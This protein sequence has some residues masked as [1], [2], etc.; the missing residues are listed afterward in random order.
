LRLNDDTPDA[1]AL[2]AAATEPEPIAA[3]DKDLGS[4]TAI[5][6]VTL[7]GIGAF[8]N[9]YATQPILPLLAKLFH[10]SKSAV[11]MTVS[12]STLG[13]AIAA[14]IAGALAEHL[15]RRRV[16]ITSIFLLALP[17]MLAATSATLPALVWWRFLQGV[18]MPG[19]F[20]VTIAYITEE[21]S[22]TAVAT[23]MSVYV[24]G[25]VLGGFLGRVF[26]GFAATHTVLPHVRPSWHVGFIAIGVCDLIF[27]LLIWRW[28]PLDRPA[29]TVTRRFNPLHHFRNRQ[30]LATYAVGFSVLFSLV[31][32][33]TYITFHLAAPP[34]E[35]TP[36]QLSWLFV[37]YL[38]GLFVTPVAGV[39][40]GRVGS[41]VSLIAA[42][43]AAM[44]GVSLTLVHSLP[45]ILL[46]LVLC[47]SGVFVC[48]SASTSYIQRAA[49]SGG[50]SSAAGQYVSFYYIGGS[51]AGVLPAYV[52]NHGEWTACVVLV[53]IV[54]A[55]TIAIAAT[56]WES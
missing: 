56:V 35:L 29:H 28:L 30:L 19:I 37:V 8:L 40:T 18:L 1:L 21:W 10:A 7:A 52:W 55:I 5:V 49:P 17:T 54:Q 22:A 4:K 9:L 16:I 15:G 45:I 33:F 38:V 39:W 2:A 24:S 44:V 46:G 11:G 23:V 36:A 13:V 41:R 27:G 51:L 20:G 14:P 25:T 48:Q 26:T 6:A 50:R 3:G 32:V 34:F 53:L 31:A 43:F 47:S 42:V 12:G